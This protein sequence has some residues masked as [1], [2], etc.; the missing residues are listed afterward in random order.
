MESKRR[1]SAFPSD[2]IPKSESVK[3][4][5]FQVMNWHLLEVMLRQRVGVRGEQRRGVLTRNPLPTPRSG[6][7]LPQQAGD[8]GLRPEGAGGV[9]HQAPLPHLMR[10][11]REEKGKNSIFHT[12]AVASCLIQKA[13]SSV[14]ISKEDSFLLFLFLSLSCYA[15]VSLSLPS[16]T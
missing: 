8:L 3:L 1:E 9:Q 7:F 2:C 10:S 4:T 12:L 15:F 16:K 13:F 6:T 11:G 5:S 14:H